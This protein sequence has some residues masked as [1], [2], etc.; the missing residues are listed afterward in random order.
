[1]EGVGV[2]EATESKY[3]LRLEVLKRTVLLKKGHFKNFAAQLMLR[4]ARPLFQHGKTSFKS[5]KTV[6]SSETSERRG[7]EGP[8]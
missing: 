4:E 6:T 5:S 2:T 3:L 7:P 1:M 8:P